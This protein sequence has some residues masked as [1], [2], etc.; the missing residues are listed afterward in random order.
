MSAG[1]EGVLL[2]ICGVGVL[3]AVVCLLLKQMKSDLLPLVRVG[4]TVLILSMILS[5]ISDAMGELLAL[6][7]DGSIEPYAKV[8]IR[9]LGISLLCKIASDVCRDAGE[10]GIGSGVELA[11]KLT[12]LLLC[13]PLIKELL[14][15]ASRLLEGG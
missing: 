13:V 14:S 6:V 11:G 7:G 5:P 10:S 8:M 15:Y 2:R 1:A 3:L 9:A 12:I 4:G